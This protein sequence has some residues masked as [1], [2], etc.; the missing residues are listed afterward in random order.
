MAKLFCCYFCGVLWMVYLPVYSVM[1]NNGLFISLFCLPWTISVGISSGFVCL[2]QQ[3]L[4][5]QPVLSVMDNIGL[6][7]NRFCLSRQ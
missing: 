3:W 1:N 4:E 2:G 7:I 6:S 5:N